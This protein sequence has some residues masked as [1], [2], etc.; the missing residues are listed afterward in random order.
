MKEQNL[1]RAADLASKVP[2]LNPRAVER[3]PLRQLLDDAYR[4]KRPAL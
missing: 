1:D 4:G 3:A 2:Y